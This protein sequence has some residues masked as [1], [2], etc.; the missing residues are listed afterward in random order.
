LVACALRLAPAINASAGAVITRD[1]S[2][3]QSV[4]RQGISR[5]AM[6]RMTANGPQF[7]HS[8]S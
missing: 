1:A 4:Q 3:P 7:A 2:P 6:R 8:K 5:S